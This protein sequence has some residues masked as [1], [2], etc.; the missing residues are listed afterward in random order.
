MLTRSP[1]SRHA[2]STGPRGGALVGAAMKTDAA[3]VI[4]R[5]KHVR[6][7]AFGWDGRICLSSLV[8]DTRPEARRIW[9]SVRRD[10][11][12]GF[13]LHGADTQVELPTELALASFRIGTNSETQVDFLHRSAC[14]AGSRSF[15]C[16]SG[17]GATDLFSRPGSYRRKPMAFR[18]ASRATDD[19]LRSSP[20]AKRLTA[21]Y[22]AW[23]RHTLT[24]NFRI[25]RAGILGR[26]RF[27]AM[28][29][30]F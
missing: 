29:A 21:R 3:C 7:R 10:A 14:P 8:P 1:A 16:R 19:M 26:P 24:W 17:C 6:A 2:S 22:S 20:S 27:L 28:D 23:L 25:S 12:T 5:S 13:R 15:L 30:A 4:D 11:G 9:P 18:S